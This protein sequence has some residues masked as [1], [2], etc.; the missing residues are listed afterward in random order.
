MKCLLDGEILA[1]MDEDRS[2]KMRRCD[3]R[4]GFVGGKKYNTSDKAEG[5]GKADGNYSPNAK[6]IKIRD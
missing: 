6:N 5:G 2:S 1:W 4:I 3:G